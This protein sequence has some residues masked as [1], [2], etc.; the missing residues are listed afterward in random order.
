MNR[1][2][3]ITALYE[4]L[5]RDDEAQG[6][7]NSITNQKKILEDFAERNGFTRCRHF[8]DDGVSGTTF[9]RPGLNEMLTVIRTGKISTVVIKDQSRIGRDVIEIGL[10]KRTFDEFNVRFMS[11]EDGLDTAKGF[12]IMSLLRDVFNEWYVA[13]CS[14]KIRAVKRMKGMAGEPLSVHAHY[15]LM[16]DPE[17]PKHRIVDEKAAEVVRQI[18]RDYMAGL[19]SGRI[20]AK[21]RE[22]RIDT[23]WTSYSAANIWDIQ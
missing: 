22:A 19:G 16:K 7:S 8:S 5:S 14:K 4:R 11:A 2:Q 10:L 18:F 21:L 17:N 9:N 12:D 6:E 1:Q 13:D 20:A 3:K 15:G 23:S